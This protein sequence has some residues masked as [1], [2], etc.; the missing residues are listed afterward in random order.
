MRSYTKPNYTKEREN[1][2][3]RYTELSL[4][5]Q[6]KVLLVKSEKTERFIPAL[7]KICTLTLVDA[8]RNH[9]RPRG[10][11]RQ[12]HEADVAIDGNGGI[13]KNR[14]TGSFFTIGDISKET[15]VRTLHV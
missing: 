10:S 9:T 1:G 5:K 15:L 2:L 12:M 7:Q 3:K 6:T 14:L 11:M 4:N 13:V 8:A